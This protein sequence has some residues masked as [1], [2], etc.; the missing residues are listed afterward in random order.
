MDFVENIKKN[1]STILIVLVLFN[2]FLFGYSYVI[3]NK[4]TDMVIKQLQKEYSPGKGY[5]P[6]LDPDKIHPDALGA[7]K[8]VSFQENAIEK[9][10]TWEEEWEE[11]RL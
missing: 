11:Q 3:M 4:T 1:L 7:P 9:P 2:T 5:G 8:K 6:R 10:L